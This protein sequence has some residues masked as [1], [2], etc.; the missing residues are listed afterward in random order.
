MTAQ[1]RAQRPPWVTGVTGATTETNPNGAVPGLS[2]GGFLWARETRRVAENKVLPFSATWG[3]LPNPRVVISSNR[4]P[5]PTLTW[6]C[7]ERSVGDFML[8]FL[9]GFLHGVN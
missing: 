4:G 3:K 8:T 9:H 6:T 1:G 2:A 5:Y 7:G